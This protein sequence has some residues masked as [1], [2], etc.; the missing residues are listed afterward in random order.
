MNGDHGL[1]WWCAP[2]GDPAKGHLMTGMNTAGYNIV[3][4]SPKVE[5]TDVR[6]VCWDQNLTELGGGK[7]TQ[8][9]IA[10]DDQVD[11]WGGYTAAAGH[12]FYTARSFP[13]KYWNR[14]AF[15]S[16]PTA[17]LVGQAILE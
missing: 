15:I 13:K 14:I 17:H 3:W 11:V 12:Q 8:V 10:T 1:L 4:F 9:V 16:E 5:F 7:W 2:G 6:R